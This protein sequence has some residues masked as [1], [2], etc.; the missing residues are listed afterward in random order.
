MA[1]DDFDDD[2]VGAADPHRAIRPDPMSSLQRGINDHQRELRDLVSIL[3][4]KAFNLQRISNWPRVTTIL[5]SAV[6][7]AKGVLDKIYGA[8]AVAPL[9]VFTAL[10]V[11]T[12]VAIGL[13]AAF[14]FEKRAADL[15]LLSATAQATVISVDSEW[16]KNIGSMD[17]TDLRQAA[18]KLI[19][20]QDTKLIE[21][22]QK[23][24]GAGIHLTLAVRELEEPTRVRY[25]A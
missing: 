22:H 11:M 14:K 21:L 24:A 20:M 13:E 4:V 10:G 18:R 5:L 6:T 7:T 17:D 12:T 2:E 16:R 25:A 1:D 15:N 9:L 8:E 3:G 19:A 23:A